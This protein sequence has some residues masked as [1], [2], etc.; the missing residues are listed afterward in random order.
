MYFNEIYLAQN[1]PVQPL[2]L[3]VQLMYFVT[4]RESAAA[5]LEVYLM[6]HYAGP[7]HVLPL[8]E[9]YECTHL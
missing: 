4:S 6:F 5:H 1:T 7:I 8:V 2:I 9:G 3:V